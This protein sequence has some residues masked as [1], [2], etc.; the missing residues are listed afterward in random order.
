MSET[1][2][3]RVSLAEKFALV[4]RPWTPK[5]VGELNGQYVKLAKFSGEFV[6]H[7]HDNEDE[8]F[9]VVKGELTLKLE[10]HD[11]TLREGEF[12]IVPRGTLHLP[13]A[14]GETHVLLFEPKST[15][16]TGELNHALTASCDWI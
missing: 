2:V 11:I 5:I 9:L 4:D 6:W 1:A 8:M 13:V 12:A 15:V 7:K 10:G 14:A 16:N 3:A